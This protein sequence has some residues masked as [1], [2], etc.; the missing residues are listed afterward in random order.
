[1]RAFTGWVARLAP[2]GDEQWRLTGLGAAGVTGFNA[3]AVRSDGIIVAGGTQGRKAWLA[4][5]DGLGKLVWEHDVAGIDDVTAMMAADNGVVVAGTFGSTTTSAGASR[6][7]SVDATGATQWST[8]VSEL[9]HGELYAIAPLS[10][11]G[12]GVGYA[13]DANGRDAAWIVRFTA[14]GAIRSSQMLST[15]T[16]AS[17]T[18][19]AAT[20]DGGFVVGGGSSD[21][22][23]GQRGRVWRFDKAGKLLWQQ[24]YGDGETQMGGVVARPLGGAIITGSTQEHGGADPLSPLRPWIFEID[25]QGV[26][27]WT[28]R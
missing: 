26:Q 8:Q 24:A 20:S 18:A 13:P 3:V 16:R 4:A 23:R 27:R 10:D 5:V 14:R 11:G 22:S 12:V 21:D 7:I 2:N 28:A 19:V 25:A 9:A 17:A 6:L 15:T 1:V